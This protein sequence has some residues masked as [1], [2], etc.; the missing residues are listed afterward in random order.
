MAVFC[1]VLAAIIAMFAGAIVSIVMMV[2]AVK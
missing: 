2:K 1:A